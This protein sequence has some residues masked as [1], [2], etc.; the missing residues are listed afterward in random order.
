[1]LSSSSSS[2][3]LV[4]AGLLISNVA[5]VWAVLALY[6]LGCVVLKV[7]GWALEVAYV[8]LWTPI[9][10]LS[11]ERHSVHAPAGWRV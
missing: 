1:M 4:V 11:L 9:Y 5:F 6:E 8:D 7:G 2:S 10:V 3:I